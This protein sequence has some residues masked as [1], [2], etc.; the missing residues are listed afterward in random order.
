MR[1]QTS[2]ASRRV[3]PA[4][5]SHAMVTVVVPTKNRPVYLKQAIRSIASQRTAGLAEV[6]VV[7]DGSDVAIE[8]S[9]RCSPALPVRVVRHETSCGASAARNAGARTAKSSWL[10][11]LDDDDRLGDGFL[12]AISERLWSD[13]DALDFAWTGRSLIDED[14]GRAVH[15]PVTRRDGRA[16]LDSLLDATCSGMLF[17]RRA[18]LD[19]GGFDESLSVSEDRDLVLRFVGQGYRGDAIDGIMLEHRVH[20]G[21]RLS[22]GGRSRRQAR[23]DMVVLER[24]EALLRRH[25]ELGCRLIGRVSKRLWSSGYREE[26]IRLA[27]LQFSLQQRSMRALR[28]L[29]WWTIQHRS[30][31]YSAR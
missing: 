20:R 18:F 7:D 28:R 16:P 19:A 22:D 11:F 5:R 13:G 25:P 9:L 6:L 14:S 27:R 2:L 21:P 26:A 1:S 31:F 30:G 8:E 15:R 17:R 4:E 29:L 23:D 24:H 10:L 12:P 3:V